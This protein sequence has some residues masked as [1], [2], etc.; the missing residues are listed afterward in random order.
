MIASSPAQSAA[1]PPLRL[2]GGGAGHIGSH[3]VKN[4]LRRERDFAN[5]DNRSTGH[6]DADPGSDGAP[7]QPIA[8]KDLA[9]KSLGWQP[10]RDDSKNIVDDAWQWKQHRADTHLY[11]DP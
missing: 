10:Q 6:H 4:L 1:S 7:I 5:F 3:T 9:H 2:L 8:E 11:T